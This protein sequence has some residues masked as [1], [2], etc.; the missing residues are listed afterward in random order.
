MDLDS[1]LELYA[2][3]PGSGRHS[4]YRVKQLPGQ[5]AA[6]GLDPVRLSDLGKDVGCPHCGAKF[7]TDKD[8]T[9][10]INDVTRSQC[11]GCN[12]VFR[13]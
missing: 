7:T 11:T 12:R 4:D 1:T 9:Y 8:N 3:G 5:G 13:H 6:R 2:G 10:T